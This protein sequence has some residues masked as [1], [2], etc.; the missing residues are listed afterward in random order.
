MNTPNVGDQLPPFRSPPLDEIRIRMYA[1]AMHDPNPVHRDPAFAK[2]VGLPGII[3]PGGMAVVALSHLVARW[4]NRD[5]VD[6]V[7][8]RLR[9]PIPAGA[10]LVC[11]AEVARIHDGRVEVRCSATT[12]DG[13]VRAD[14]VVW[15]RS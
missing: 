10:R 11:Q 3:A 12:E 13:V 1:D 15:V 2:S 7:D 14:G 5:G 4:A 6:E 8:I 9:A